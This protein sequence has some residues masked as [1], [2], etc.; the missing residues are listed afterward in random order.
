MPASKTVEKPSDKTIDKKN[1][2]KNKTDAKKHKKAGLVFPVGRLN[3]MIR[4]RRL[5]P[6]VS[7]SAGVFMAA[8]LEYLCTEVCDLAGNAAHEKKMKTIMPRHLQLSLVNDEDLNKL[9]AQTTIASGGVI[10]HLHPFLW[11]KKGKK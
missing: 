7:P 9:V 2:N 4:T 10:P 6:Q 5:S 3:R 11:A 1:R 8:V